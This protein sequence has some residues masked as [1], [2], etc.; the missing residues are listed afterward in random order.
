MMIQLA[1]S[2]RFD[3]NNLYYTVLYVCTEIARRS[4]VATS[5]WFVATTA[6][7]LLADCCTS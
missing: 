3:L 6:C 7:W 1:A 5:S 4:F 2:R